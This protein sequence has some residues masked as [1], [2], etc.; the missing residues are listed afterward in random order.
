MPM[1]QLVAD[2]RPLPA[3]GRS[4]NSDIRS[5]LTAAQILAPLR[6]AATRQTN[7]ACSLLAQQPAPTPKWVSLESSCF[8]RRTLLQRAHPARNP[9][10]QRG[11]PRTR[12]GAQDRAHRADIFLS[13]FAGPHHYGPW[14]IPL[15]KIV[16]GVAKSFQRL[17]AATAPGGR[18]SMFFKYSDLNDCFARCS[19]TRR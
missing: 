4:Q 11:A 7:R 18:A 14:S 10:S 3:W 8:V 6:L 13:P 5:P 17:L 19:S 16:Q 2:S 9:G 15:M 12:P 1:A